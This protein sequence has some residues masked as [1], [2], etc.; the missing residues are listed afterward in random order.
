MFSLKRR[1]ISFELMPH[2][3]IGSLLL[4]AT[5]AEVS[6]ALHGLRIKDT[7][8]NAS[9]QLH[10]LENTIE[11]EFNSMD[12]VWFIGLYDHPMVKLTFGDD[13]LFDIP[14]RKSFQKL[15]LADGTEDVP[16]SRDDVLLPRLIVTLWHAERKNVA[17]EEIWTQI[18]LGTQ[19]YKERSSN[20]SQ[21]EI[22]GILR[23][24][25]ISPE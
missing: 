11:I 5:R 24:Y 14:A 15:S 6:A 10:A 1:F 18:G 7:H 23:K 9:G 16:F 13:S 17:A 22:D 21:D 3:G 4:D 12:R 25:G 8:E 19:E 2:K 20:I